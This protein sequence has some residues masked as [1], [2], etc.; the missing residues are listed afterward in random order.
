MNIEK[1][2]VEQ[3][4]ESPENIEAEI[5]SKVVDIYKEKD[6]K[7]KYL[8][9]WDV[10][11]I[12]EHGVITPFYDYREEG[13]SE[14]KQSPLDKQRAIR[15]KEKEFRQMDNLS[16]YDK[17]VMKF[18]NRANVY[19]PEGA[20]NLVYSIIDGTFDLESATMGKHKIY[21][22]DVG[23]TL[24]MFIENFPISQI[25]GIPR[26]LDL[27]NLLVRYLKSKGLLQTYEIY[28]GN[29]E[30]RLSEEELGIFLKI[31]Q[32][33]RELIREAVVRN[34]FKTH[35]VPSPGI[36]FSKNLEVSKSYDGD[37]PEQATIRDI[38]NKRHIIGLTLG[39]PRESILDGGF[40]DDGKERQLLYIMNH[41]DVY[42]TIED[43]R[44]IIKEDPELERII[45]EYEVKIIEEGYHF[46]LKTWDLRNRIESRDWNYLRKKELELASKILETDKGTTM[47]DFYRR[48]GEKYKLPIYDRKGN[49][50]WPQKMTR[51]Q[52]AKL[53]SSQ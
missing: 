49:L 29:K 13:D 34:F 17:E 46:Y 5:M 20:F 50:L 2:N 52:I 14:D 7:F 48:L 39:N 4:E 6:L 24:R 40:P 53:K 35:E 9:L 19:Y 8:Y 15:D 23:T 45:K 28:R 51:S 44:T 47:V 3:I 25:K 38:N 42:M 36:I 31:I 16:H 41:L 27:T 32:E 18:T 10:K 43:L 37:F 30:P 1:P 21:L 12:L 26:N 33:N 22:R 11:K